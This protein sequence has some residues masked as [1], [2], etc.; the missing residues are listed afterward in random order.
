VLVFHGVDGIGWK[1]KTGADLREYFGYIKSKEDQVWVATFQDV[2]KY[3]RERMHGQVHSYRE[4]DAVSVVLRDDLTDES[5]DLP[6]TLK[7]CV[8]AEW[9]AAEVRQ[10]GRSGRVETIRLNGANFVLYQ[11]MPNAE[12]V[13]ITPVQ[14]GSR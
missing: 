12:V 8:P 7:T 11:A 3:I 13:K 9:R 1:P 6:L 2:T 10:G 14:T 5:Y 4:G